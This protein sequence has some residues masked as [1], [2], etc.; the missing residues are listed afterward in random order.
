MAAL[1]VRP[2]LLLDHQD[3]HS[4]FLLMQYSFGLAV[5]VVVLVRI[6]RCCSECRLMVLVRVRCASRA[7]RSISFHSFRVKTSTSTCSCVH[8]LMATG[9]G[10]P[11]KLLAASH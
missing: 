11:K 10:Q 3:T 8:R 1:I 6:N 2:Q 4:M 9:C 7:A 5:G